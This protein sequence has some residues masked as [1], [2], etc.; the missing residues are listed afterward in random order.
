LSQNTTK[1]HKL[2][3]TFTAQ[4]LYSTKLAGTRILQGLAVLIRQLY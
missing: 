3:G 4:L 1:L 2:W